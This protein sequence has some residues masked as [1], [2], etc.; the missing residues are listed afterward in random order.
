MENY[1]EL[2]D[3]NE[4]PDADHQIESSHQIPP[5]SEKELKH[6]SRRIKFNIIK[7]LIREASLGPASFKVTL[8]S[9]ICLDDYQLK[10]QS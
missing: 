4:E 2:E 10:L 7:Y 5:M 3:L 9:S 1:C 6:V 8:P